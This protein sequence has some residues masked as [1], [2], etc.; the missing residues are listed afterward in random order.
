MGDVSNNSIKSGSLSKNNDLFINADKHLKKD[1][2]VRL[3]EIH[4]E[5][6]DGRGKI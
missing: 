5:F 1:G 2:T 3:Y 6:S 4:I